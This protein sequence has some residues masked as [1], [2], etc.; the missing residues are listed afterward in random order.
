MYNLRSSKL[1]ARDES[2]VDVVGCFHQRK[3]Q[4]YKT[5]LPDEYITARD[6]VGGQYSVWLRRLHAVGKIWDSDPTKI[7]KFALVQ[8]Q[9]KLNSVR[10]ASRPP[11]PPPDSGA[12]S[13]P[14]TF[15]FASSAPDFDA[16]PLGC[17]CV[18]R[19]AGHP[20]PPPPPL[21]RR[22]SRA[23]IDY[24]RTRCTGSAR[25]SRWRS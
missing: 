19:S 5:E 14:A 3:T 25:T 6:A 7:T 10:R 4:I 13:R 1:E 22:P 17:A 24:R 15:P 16:Q 21:C 8:E 23:S 9:Q 12:A 11:L 2:S 18:V 20:R